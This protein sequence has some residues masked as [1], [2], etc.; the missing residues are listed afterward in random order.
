MKATRAK[1]SALP[2]NPRPPK[3]LKPDSRPQDNEDVQPS[4]VRENSPSN[5]GVEWPLSPVEGEPKTPGF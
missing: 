3:T 2:E 5:E 1:R 4:G